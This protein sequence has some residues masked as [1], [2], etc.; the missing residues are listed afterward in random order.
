MTDHDASIQD[1]W[2]QLSEAE[3]AAALAAHRSDE[4]TLGLQ[5]SL[6]TAGLAP[7]EHEKRL[8]AFPSGVAQFLK[9]RHDGI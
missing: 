7:S 3:Q 2:N 5:Q 1:W 6:A 9:T 8:R 4:L